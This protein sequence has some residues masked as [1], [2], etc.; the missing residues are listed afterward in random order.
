MKPRIKFSPP[1]IMVEGEIWDG[2]DWLLVPQLQESH[3]QVATI[4]HIQMLAI[5]THLKKYIHY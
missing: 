3:R 2:V 1:I 5:F 4:N